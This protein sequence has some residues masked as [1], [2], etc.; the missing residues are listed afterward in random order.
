MICCITSLVFCIPIFFPFTKEEQNQELICQICG[1]FILIPILLSFIHLLLSSVHFFL[2][3]RNWRALWQISAGVI[4]WAVGALIYTDL[5]IQADLPSP[6]PPEEL[7]PIQETAVLH[8]ANATLLGPSALTL[9]ISPG[10]EEATN[11]HTAEHLT[12]LETNHSDLFSEFLRTAPRWAYAAN[13]DTFYS[14]PGHVVLMAS[15]ASGIPGTVHAAFRTIAAGEQM[16]TGYQVI[17][18]GDAV[19]NL[20]TENAEEIPDIALELGGK[21]YLL[22]AWRGATNKSMA[23]NA[24]NAAIAEI[25]KQMAP[26]A[27]APTKETIRQ[28]VQAPAPI[29]GNQPEL[30]LSEPPSQFGIY[31]AEI[32]ANPG[33]AGTLILVI[34][35]RKNNQPLLVFA[36]E[37]QFS[38]NPNELFRHDV[39]L[40]MHER[41]G[42]RHMGLKTALFPANAPF[43]ALAEGESHIYFGISVEVHFSPLNSYGEVTELLL[44]RNYNVQA[45][46]KPET[47]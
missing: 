32:Y 23:I 41:Y 17:K 40:P 5:A 36:Q 35:D 13:D 7:P 24:V 42:V 12:E 8:E 1:W 28:L 6:Y 29:S 25:D 11:I 45:Y 15:A 38:H 2:N 44:R 9:S 27:E 14:K 31:Q 26:L 18:P 33:R 4:V 43:F 22:L 19:E 20:V 3:L 39:P 34:R 10:K 16:P 30:R 21:R 47:T 46:E 37:A